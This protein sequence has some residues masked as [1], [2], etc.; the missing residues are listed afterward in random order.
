M[1]KSKIKVIFIFICAIQFLY[2]FT[3][4]S[5]FEYSIL[6][7]SF[8]KDFGGNFTV[9]K[10]VSEANKL[11]KKYCVKNFH[12]SNNIRNNTHLYQRIVEFNY[13]IINKNKSEFLITLKNEISTCSIVESGKFVILLKC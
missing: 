13:P 3:Y 1:I 10:E 7:N 2:L 8:K 5:N 12:L 4:R 11:F 9:P 6:K